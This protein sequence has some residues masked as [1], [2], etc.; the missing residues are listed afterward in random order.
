MLV[1]PCLIGQYTS[2]YGEI[3]KDSE[4][5]RRKDGEDPYVVGALQLTSSRLQGWR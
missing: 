2:V 5:E 3:G 1:R 4:A